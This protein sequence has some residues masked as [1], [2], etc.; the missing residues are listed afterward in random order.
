[1]VWSVQKALLDRKAHQ[2]LIQAQR[3]SLSFVTYLS[4][5]KHHPHLSVSIVVMVLLIRLSSAM[6]E[7]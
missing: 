3:L 5:R 2:D 6:M 1:M 4:R 7:T